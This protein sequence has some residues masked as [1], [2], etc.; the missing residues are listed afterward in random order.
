MTVYPQQMNY[1]P[2]APSPMDYDAAFEKQRIA[3][4]TEK[5]KQ[6]LLEKWNARYAGAQIFPDAILSLNPALRDFLLSFQNTLFY[7]DVARKFNLSREQRDALPQIIWQ[8]CLNKKWE[9][10][11]MSLISALSINSSVADQILV[12]LNQTIL[13]RARELSQQNFA[14]QGG[15]A[16]FQS[17]PVEDRIISLTLNDALKHYPEIGEQLITSKHI[18]L[19]NFPEPVRP[20][21]KNWL[22][23]YTFTIGYD[24][25]DSIKRGD[26]VFHGNNT[27]RLSSTDRQ[28]LAY[29]LKA[30]DEQAAV[31]INKSTKQVVFPALEARAPQMQNANYK[32][33]TALGHPMSLD[34]N[35]QKISG[36]PSESRARLFDPQQKSPLPAGRQSLKPSFSNLQQPQPQVNPQSSSALHNNIS[37]SSA[38]KLPYEKIS[39]AQSEEID[40]QQAKEARPQ[41]YTIRPIFSQLEKKDEP[42]PLP[43]NVVNLKEA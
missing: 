37:F 10:L 18:S 16:G 24:N 38:Q 29:I 11:R 5:I 15:R 13:L 3:E 39:P 14:A 35:D 41:A 28:K 22:A 21:I 2:K 25:K 32:V 17:E 20:S 30:Y 9:Q 36:F 31:T 4:A 12:S 42:R 8:I 26:Y 6:E 27:L 1:S 23:D 40:T 7:N 34:H 19:K 33:R 43:K